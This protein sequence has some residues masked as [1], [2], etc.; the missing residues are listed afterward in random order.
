MLNRP[1]IAGKTGTTN[2]A[3]DA[4]FA[5]YQNRIVAVSW[6]GF[7]QPKNLGSREFGGGLALPVWINYMQTALRNQLIEDR[8]MPSS[9]TIV[10]GD[11]QYVDPPAPIIKSIV[12]E[13]SASM[14]AA[15]Q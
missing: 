2:N 10:D 1:D 11:Y 15:G 6:I 7:D 5:G 12:A 9:I 8:P 3:V 4:W 13:T 14:P